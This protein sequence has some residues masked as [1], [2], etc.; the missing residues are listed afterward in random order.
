MCKTIVKRISASTSAVSVSTVAFLLASLSGSLI[1]LQSANAQQTGHCN[2]NTQ[3]VAINIPNFSPIAKYSNGV[4]QVSIPQALLASGID[5][6]LR[7]NE[8]R[9]KDTEFQKI[10][11]R[12]MRFSLVQERFDACGNRPNCI[13]SVSGSG[14]LESGFR[15]DGD[16]QFQFRE[17]IG[18]A[19]GKCHYTDYISVSG[20]FSQPLY[21]R[22]SNSRLDL[23]P[24]GI[25]IRGE[26]WYADA[27]SPIAGIFD[28]HGSIKE[29]LRGAI[30]DI[31]GMDLRQ[32]LIDYGSRE[33][34]NQ[35]GIDQQV[36][37]QLISQNVGNISAQVS[38]G[39]L[40]VSVR[41]PLPSR[42][43]SGEFYT[44][45]IGEH[46]Q[47]LLNHEGHGDWWNSIQ[48]S[49]QRDA[50]NAASEQYRKRVADHCEW[51]LN[52]QGRTDWWNLIEASAR[53]DAGL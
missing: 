53:R 50:G 27:V 33:V 23:Q 9:V 17:K 25:T 37:S 48:S 20:S 12:N 15:V 44:K 52:N 1:T 8:G 51:L 3:L 38:E 2:E 39:N 41:F 40:V 29:N 10:D 11:V 32:V 18:C 21:F 49:A 42:R 4:L 46:C 19:F 43:A 6:V 35:V 26:R 5:Q 7:A 36:V 22:I 34:V 28:V 45:R 16:W 13:D 14:R 47:W 30:Q 24:G 31:N